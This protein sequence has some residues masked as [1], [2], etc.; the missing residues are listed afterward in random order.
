MEN[1]L[2][3]VPAQSLDELLL[4]AQCSVC[5]ELKTDNRLLSGCGHSFCLTDL[6]KISKGKQE[7]TC[8]L[9]RKPFQIP[10]KGVSSFIMDYNKNSL[11]ELALKMSEFAPAISTKGKYRGCSKDATIWCQQCDELFCEEHS[12]QFHS[13]GA[14]KSHSLLPPTNRV[15]KIMCSDHPTKELD[16]YCKQCSHV[17]CDSC[18][19]YEHTSHSLYPWRK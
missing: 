3:S 19:K 11:A 6:E 14:F 15:Q 18:L 5:N 7:S 17:I 4:L 1:E 8:P 12:K 16:S 9:C 2:K 10:A 13:F